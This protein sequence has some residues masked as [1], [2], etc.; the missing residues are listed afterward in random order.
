MGGPRSTPRSVGT[1]SPSRRR[2]STGASLDPA[3]RAPGREGEHSPHPRPPRRGARA[4][5]KPSLVAGPRR[6]PPAATCPGDPTGPTRAGSPTDQLKQYQQLIIV[7]MTK[8][9]PVFLRG[10]LLDILR[11]FTCLEMRDL[12]ADCEIKRSAEQSVCLELE[13]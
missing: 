7:G 12:I 5:I 3:P 11:E 9:Q 10:F 13:N 4:R 2:W 8:D 1:A 6:E